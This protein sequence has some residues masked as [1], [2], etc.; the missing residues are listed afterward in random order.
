MFPEP[1]LLKKWMSTNA[2]SCAFMQYFS[3]LFF[4]FF[5]HLFK[6]AFSKHIHNIIQ[7]S[8]PNT[9]GV[10][11]CSHCF[12][13]TRGRVNDNQTNIWPNVEFKLSKMTEFEVFFHERVPK[14]G[15]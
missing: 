5:T 2:L 10:K 12:A 14:L 8:T 3:L 9:D 13:T 7:L 15:F 4:S 6:Q 1:A 11:L